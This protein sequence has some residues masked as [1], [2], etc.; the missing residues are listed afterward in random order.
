VSV[1]WDSV[2]VG[3]VSVGMAGLAYASSSRAASRAVIV[4]RQEATDRARLAAET[5]EAKAYERAKEI[6]EAALA[7]QEHQIDGLR[8]QI[9]ILELR[10]AS[11]ER[12]IRAADIP[13]P[14]I[15]P[16]PDLE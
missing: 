12:T 3:V 11:L 10:I 13:M 6:Y 15:D 14:P 16:H 1:G 2:I 9:G 7:Q 4:A 8:A 5:V